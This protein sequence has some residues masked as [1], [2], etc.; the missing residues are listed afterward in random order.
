MLSKN[1][2]RLVKGIA[3][4]S[5]VKDTVIF[6]KNKKTRNINM[7]VNNIEIF[8]KKRKTKKCKYSRERYENL[9]EYEKQRLAEYRKRY[10]KMQKSIV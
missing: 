1:K 4:T 2:K 10:S 8:F 6:P 9:P 3:I 7:L 5:P